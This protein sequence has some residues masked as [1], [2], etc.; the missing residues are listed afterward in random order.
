MSYIPF[1]ISGVMLNAFAQIFLKKGMMSVEYFEFS[2]DNLYPVMIKSATN[3]YILFGLLFYVVSVVIWMLVLS[4]VEVSYAYPFLSIGYV[5][6]I[7]M[8]Y[9]LFNENITLLRLAGVGLI[10]LG[11]VLVSRS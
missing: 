7:I 4:R 6:T 2:V 1:I 11:V 3:A 9:L 8:G 5:I 10:C